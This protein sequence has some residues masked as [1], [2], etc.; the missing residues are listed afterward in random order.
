[1]G[2]VVSGTVEMGRPLVPSLSSLGNVVAFV[3][4][5]ID[6]SLLEWLDLSVLQDK[7]PELIRVAGS[8][9]SFKGPVAIIQYPTAL[10]VMCSILAG[11]AG[12]ALAYAGC[13]AVMGVLSNYAPNQIRGV[14]IGVAVAAATGLSGIFYASVLGSVEAGV[15]FFSASLV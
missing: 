6:S 13:A 14:S 8:M 5:N 12:A 4:A 3:Q 10:R 2:F 7:Y 15:Y 11:A 1:M 9:V